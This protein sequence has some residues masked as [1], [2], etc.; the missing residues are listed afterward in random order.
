MGVV[1]VLGVV[2]C[3]LAAE[4]AE[5]QPAC[6]AQGSMFTGSCVAAETDTYNFTIKEFSFRQEGTTIFVPV[7]DTELA[8]C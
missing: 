7:S 2:A 4:T 3:L 8:G 5:G 1:V 6:A